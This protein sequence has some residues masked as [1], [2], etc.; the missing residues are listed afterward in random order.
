MGTFNLKASIQPSI[1]HAV[2]R[3]KAAIQL[4]VQQR[5]VAVGGAISQIGRMGEQ[6]SILLL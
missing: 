6:I 2:W 3:L 5:D 1:Q 4:S